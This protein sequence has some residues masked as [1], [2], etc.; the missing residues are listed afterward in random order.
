MSWEKMARVFRK[1]YFTKRKAELMF[2]WN[3]WLS[4]IQPPFHALELLFIKKARSFFIFSHTEFLFWKMATSSSFKHNI[5]FFKC[6]MWPECQTESS[7]HLF[8]SFLTISLP[9]FHKQLTLKEYFLS[10]VSLSLS[11]VKIS[12]EQI[13]HVILFKLFPQ[14]FKSV[15]KPTKR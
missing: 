9:Y 2:K 12:H 1:Y 8:S 5:C 13:F 6:P 10:T 11:G 14:D 3:T 7:S 15:D 4:V